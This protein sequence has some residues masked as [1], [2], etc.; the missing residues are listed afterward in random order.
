[1]FSGDVCLGELLIKGTFARIYKGTLQDGTNV[2]IK[3]VTGKT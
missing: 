1:M 2:L 3:T